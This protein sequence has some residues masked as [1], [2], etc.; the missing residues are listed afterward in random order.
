MTMMKP[1]IQGKHGIPRAG[2]AADGAP[3]AGRSGVQLDVDRDGDPVD[4][5]SP[6]RITSNWVLDSRWITQQWIPGLSRCI[7][8]TC[9]FLLEPEL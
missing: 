1:G 7:T 5:S 3:L 9:S 2:P 8:M 4:D 6:F